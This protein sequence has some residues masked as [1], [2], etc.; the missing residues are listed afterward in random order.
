MPKL[1]STFFLAAIATAV[2]VLA[3]SPTR[4]GDLAPSKLTVQIVP[5]ASD[6][7]IG[8]T[9]SLSNRDRDK[10]FHV[11][12]TNVSGEPISLWEEW[13]SWGYFNLAFEARDALGRVT[14]IY[15][16]SGFWDKNFPCPYLLRPGEPFIID[17]NF[18]PSIWMNSP[19]ED[20][21]GKVTLRLK[22]IYRAEAYQEE[23]F[24]KWLT[25]PAVVWTGSVSS[26]EAEY[27]IYW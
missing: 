1:L 25:G 5:N 11:V 21:S 24:V 6:G 19:L 23:P 4:A 26:A 17:V 3:P 22:A 8:E 27:S 7:K 10:H 9:I 18:A 20:P 15:K 14:Q 13:C 12:V 16:R 2:I